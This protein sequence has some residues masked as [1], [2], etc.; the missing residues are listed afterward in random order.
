MR[1]NSE[2]PAHPAQA[3]EVT[4]TL[5]ANLHARPAGQLAKAAA[6]LQSAITLEH[7]GRTARASGILAVIALGATA[8]SAVTVRA[9]G[10]DAETA[11]DAIAELLSNAE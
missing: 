11:V 10:P 9:E 6:R 5:P 8:G 2:P 1:T 3:A 4:V 7:A